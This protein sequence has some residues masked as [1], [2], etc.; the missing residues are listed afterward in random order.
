LAMTRFRKPRTLDEVLP[1]F[2]QHSK[3]CEGT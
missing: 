2:Q 1:V 3:A